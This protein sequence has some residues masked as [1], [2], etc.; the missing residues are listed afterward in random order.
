M[1][2][3]RAVLQ[4]IGPDHK[5][6]ASLTVDELPVEVAMAVAFG[7]SD[8]KQSVTLVGSSTEKTAKPTQADTDDRMERIEMRS[9]GLSTSNAMI[10]I[11]ATL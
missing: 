7:P 1:H 2:K 4:V 8:K 6:R 10:D 5:L 9:S 11:A 3:Q